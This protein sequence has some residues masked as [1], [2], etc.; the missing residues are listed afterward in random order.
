MDVNER[1]T[2]HEVVG[3]WTH[4]HEEDPK[5]G[6]GR[7]VYRPTSW[8]FGPSR[9]RRSFALYPDKRATMI[10]IAAADG[11]EPK[12]GSWSI[13]S[14]NVLLIHTGGA[15]RR[16]KVEHVSSDRLVIYELSETQPEWE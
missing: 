2:D 10:D 13:G 9:G 5:D 11:G 12:A 14:D 3:E 8:S 7:Q 16:M 1:V 4:A 15:I 6:S